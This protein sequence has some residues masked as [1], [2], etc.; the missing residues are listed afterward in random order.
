[1]SDECP[2]DNRPVSDRWL[3][4]LEAADLLGI[5]PEAVRALARRQ[6]WPRQSPNAIGRSVRIQIPADRLRPVTA[7]GHDQ[8]GQW[9]RPV[10]ADG[11]DRSSELR[12]MVEIFMA[13]M[14]EQVADLKTQLV[15]ERDRA[16]Y[17]DDR[18]RDAEGRVR[19]LQEKLAAEMIEHRRVV[20]LLAEQLA[21]RSWW[22]WRRR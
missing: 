8:I 16:N 13:P 1:M 14:R 4:Y 18:A 10:T 7:N 22:P 19:E 21:R 2:P 5:S 15:A 20:S 11:H 6:K 3:T 9:P 12:E 17:A